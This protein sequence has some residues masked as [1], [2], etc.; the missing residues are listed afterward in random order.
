M[1]LVHRV[2]TIFRYRTVRMLVITSV[3]FV[4]LFAFILISL[5]RTFMMPLVPRSIGPLSLLPLPSR[6]SQDDVLWIIKTGKSR[7]SRLEAQLQAMPYK[8]NDEDDA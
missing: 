7:R 4:V 2:K 3:S 6:Y 8:V 1:R 5:E